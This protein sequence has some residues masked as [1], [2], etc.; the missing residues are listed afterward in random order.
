MKKIL[1]PIGTILLSGFVQAQISLTEN[2]VQSRTYLEPVTTSS[3]T[4]KQI[5][6][7]QYFDG[8]GRPKQ[9]VN[10]KAS[11]L[12]RDVV[13]P[14]LY[15][16]FGRQTMD[17]L[18]V[19]QQG[20]NN[21]AIYPQ[22]NSGNFPVGDPSG[23]YTNER[24]FSEKIL[25]SSPLDRILQQKQ[26][27]LAWD[28]KPVQFGY[29]AN[30][31]G[32]AV[33]KYTT[34]TTWVNGAT[35]SVLSQSTNYGTAQLYK[36]TVTDED[37]NVT[38]EFKNGEGQ[39]LLVRKMISDTEK[40]DTYYV[41]N[42]YNQLAFVIS[43]KAA[44]E[45]DPNTVL[46]DLCYQ[47]KY[48]GRGRL[49]EKKIPGKGWEYIVYDKADRVFMTQDANMRP[50]GNWLL[51]RY[52]KLSRVVYTAIADIGNTYARKDVQDAV[53]Y[54]SVTAA[55]LTEERTGAVGFTKSGIDIYY[56]NNTYPTNAILQVLSINYYDIYPPGSPTIPIQILGQDVLPQD[57]QNSSIST[58]SLPVASY[59]KNIEDDN[60][61]KNYT[62]YDKKGRS[63]G[64]YSFNHLGGY[65]K[66][67][68]ELDFAGVA[69]KTN[70]S[71][72]RKLGEIG[73][74]VQERFVYDSQN[75]LLQHYHKVDDQTEVLLAENI[76]NELSQVSNK[77][78][79][80]NLQS[81]D[82]SYN[83]RGWMTGINRDQMQIPD[84]GGK[85]FSYKI[86]YN[87]KEGISS[88][89]LTQFPGKEVKAKYNG[90]IA[91]VDWRSVE[92]IGNYPSLTPKRYGY[93]Y[94]KL[95]RLTA[96][97]YQTPNNPSLG[98]NTESL[99]YDLNGNITRLFRTSVL[100]YGNTTPTK[101]DDLE[102]I[103]SAQ[104]KSNELIMINDNS[105]NATGY[106]GGGMPIQYDA[107]GN[108]T[109][110]PDKTMQI[111][112][113]YL[114]LPSVVDMIVDFP[115][116]VEYSYRADG[117]KLRKKSTS[118]I[119]G[120]NSMTT[121]VKDAD[122]L[123]GFQYNKTTSTTQGGGGGPVDPPMESMAMAPQ[124]RAMEMQAY[125][126]DERLFP[127]PI[128]WMLKNEDLE[129]F[130]TAEGYYDYKKDQYIYQ[131][132]DHLGN[133]RISFA[134]NSAGALEL[135]DVNDYYPFG[136]NHMKSGNSFFGAGSY[137]NYKYNG[138]ELQEIGMYDYGARF[139]MADIGRWGVVDP[140]AEKMTRHSPYNYAF[141]NPMR[142][143]DPDG[144]EGEDWVQRGNQIFFDAAIKTQEQAKDKYGDSAEHLAEGS[145]LMT[146]NGEVTSEL[147]F[148]DNGTIT[149][150]DGSEKSTKETFETK[151]G[152]TIIGTESKGSSISFSA[153]GVL[154]GG[155]GFDIGLVKDAGNNWGLFFNRNI[156]FGLGFEGGVGV[157]RISSSH[158]GPFLLEDYSGEA[159][160][161]I[162]PLGVT[163]GG[164]F[165]PKSTPIEMMNPLN[166]GAGKRGTTEI[167]SGLKGI[168]I[169]W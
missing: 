2:Y 158:S 113:N 159:K 150:A 168:G 145:T 87:E 110:M 32:D 135:V 53:N 100:E 67:E 104:N 121:I 151:G 66:T 73:V 131:Y 70:T 139:Y 41:Y 36:N 74:T 147:T 156:N 142:F 25:E 109:S 146:T 108:M 143:I 49:V 89:D 91:E 14:I 162:S 137:K 134:R 99:E 97:F 83:I 56:G 164:T 20:T 11:P 58:K 102:Y 27:G 141:N 24:P 9:V 38:I 54:H 1:M 43:P 42:E 71:H 3:S 48:D 123:D 90:N 132:K 69:Q 39:V 30:T 34:I 18:P 160:S 28:N 107:N 44:V 154:G 92:N 86:K 72:L 152:I 122:Y 117:V 10:V 125:S 138:K 31:T 29:D 93:A 98:E 169:F 15:D 116:N 165:D 149:K 127:T 115:F 128:T 119:A 35:S 157:G 153:N 45:T 16:G 46:G 6:T 7:V 59:V 118:T 166:V 47:Y 79:G 101:I 105:Y 88:P 163:Y 85:L 161:F 19:P 78:V 75:R 62:W 22:Q 81:I 26:V 63:I 112:Y 55:S 37:G 50:S 140:L 51:T 76:Y 33:K 155:F 114:N 5:E 96:G 103:Y 124:R 94:D 106:E 21:G 144:K 4:A 130:P 13:T 12:G 57:S 84:L 40:A 129:F 60:W 111:Q 80:N 133:T 120:V 64:T 17:F 148:H 136:M 167:S 65:T 8:L 82:Y 126:V 23:V 95:N 68:T 77:K 61:T 52:D